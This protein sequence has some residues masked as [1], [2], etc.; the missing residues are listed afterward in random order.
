MSALR[1]CV[2]LALLLAV[3][4]AAACSSRAADEGAA[5]AE[6]TDADPITLRVMSFNIEWGGAHV[7]FASVAEAIRTADADIVGVQEP[8][9][10]LER[11]AR[12]LGWY[13]N[14]RNHVISKYPLVDP[15]GADGRFLFVEV[16]PGRMVAMANVHLPS[17]PYGPDWLREGRPPSE[18]IA[19]ERRVRLPGI[20]PVL[21][22]LAPIH[23]QGVPVFLTGDFNSPS[24]ADRIPAAAG[25]F[26]HDALELAW[27]V[28][29]AIADS[30]L[31]DSYREVHPD[32]V[33]TPGFTWWAARPRIEDYNPSDPTDQARIDFLWFAGPANVLDSRVVGEQG[34]RDVE[35]SVSPWPSDHR[36]VVSKFEVRATPMPVLVA[37]AQRVHAAGESIQA[38]YNA[39]GEERL[40][41]A[42]LRESGS[43]NSTPRH[44]LAV[45]ADHGRVDLTV[46]TVPAGHYR[47]VLLD[48]DGRA[49]S[50][51][52]LWML[53]PD[54]S[55]AITVEGE[56]YGPGEPVNVRWR[57]APGNRLDWIA[58]FEA[59]APPDSEDYV[60]YGYI[61]ARSSG[62]L[63]LDE[64]TADFGWPL[65]PGRYVA[66]LLEDD[67]Y[68]VLAESTEFTVEADVNAASRSPALDHVQR[69]VAAERIRVGGIVEDALQAVPEPRRVVVEQVVHGQGGLHSLE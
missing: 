23:G 4:A 31:R 1:R 37:T 53:A 62:A 8:E 65:P 44:R 68:E 69:D 45:D 64:E 29:R 18:V 6:R 61:G 12:D 59:G 47:I 28:S 35:I 51:N 63:A 14:R 67:G 16:A 38:Y 41:I 58:V 7:R 20:E 32:P 66:R 27:P 11:L 55:P 15:P 42:L 39:P 36:A 10:N 33:A 30:G 40:S 50:R 3:T 54:A 43:G 17:D 13:F 26:P 46:D 25:K 57:N 9:G 22:A 60:A 5:S 52:E 24:H 48:A 56:H 21:A 2:N 19:L 49:L 34:A